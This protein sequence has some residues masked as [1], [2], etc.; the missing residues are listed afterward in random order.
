MPKPVI[1]PALEF[2]WPTRLRPL[3]N[4]LSQGLCS[5]AHAHQD[6]LLG[7]SV[8]HGV[9]HS[10]IGGAMSE[11]GCA[12]VA[13]GDGRTCDGT[14]FRLAPQAYSIIELLQQKFLDDAYPA[15]LFNRALGNPGCEFETIHF[16]DF[17]VVVTYDKDSAEREIDQIKVVATPARD[18]RHADRRVAEI[19]ALFAF[20]GEWHDFLNKY[21]FELPTPD[22]FLRAA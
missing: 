9:G 3:I 14:V 21:S 20:L 12:F 22:M 6:D 18:A 8:I 11:Y 2:N 1:R 5:L 10:Y 7:F 17:N 16:A 19:A 15:R 13:T 4:G